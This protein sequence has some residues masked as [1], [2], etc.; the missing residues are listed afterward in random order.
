MR[1]HYDRYVLGQGVQKIKTRAMLLISAGVLMVG[2]G[3][4]AMVS[5]L[6]NAA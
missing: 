4:A 5:M 3:G 2:S 6:G 1:L